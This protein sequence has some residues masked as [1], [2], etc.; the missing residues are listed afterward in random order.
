MEKKHGWTAEECREFRRAM[1]DIGIMLS[2]AAVFT[3]GSFLIPGLSKQFQIMFWQTAM[4]AVFS[5]CVIIRR[6][7]IVCQPLIPSR[8]LHCRN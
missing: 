7:P 6:H 2:V 3:L 5:A 8:F 4:V 1:R